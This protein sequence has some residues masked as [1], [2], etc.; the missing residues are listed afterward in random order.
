MSGPLGSVGCGLLS[1]VG[2]APDHG[3]VDRRVFSQ[4]SE[5]LLQVCILERSEWIMRGIVGAGR[6]DFRLLRPP[7]RAAAEGQISVPV[8]RAP[9]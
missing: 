1:K 6:S 3:P 4:G 8:R 2:S 7:R 9:G 5:W